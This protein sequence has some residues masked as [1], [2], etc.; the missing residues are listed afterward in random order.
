ML[1]DQARVLCWVTAT[2]E[3][4]RA[5]ERAQRDLGEGPC[6]DAFLLDQVVW[7]ADL[8]VDPRWPRLGPAARDNRIRGVLSAPVSLTGRVLGTCN[9]ITWTSRAWTE[10]ETKSVGSFA[11][12][13][14]RLL[15][16]T[17]E[18]HHNGDL[19]TQLQG[20]L[21]SRILIE[22][23]KGVLMERD[24]ISDLEAFD[25]LRRQARWQSRTINEVAREVIASRA[26]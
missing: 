15:G 19:V 10:A 9:V 18:A 5:F 8:R 6:I 20:A 2:G 24:G 11:T 16:A 1:A 23:A 25:R 14:G 13:I 4:E 17:S 26:P 7:T 22:Q 21:E 12:L 3:A